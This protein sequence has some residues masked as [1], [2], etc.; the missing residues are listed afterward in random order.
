MNMSTVMFYSLSTLATKRNGGA[1]TAAATGFC[2]VVGVFGGS[3]D[4]VEGLRTGP[5]FGDVCFADGDGS[6]LV[7][8]LDGER[9]LGWNV[10]LEDG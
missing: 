3:E 1:A 4:G 8:P 2:K 9:V 5:E 7:D 6:G 10:V